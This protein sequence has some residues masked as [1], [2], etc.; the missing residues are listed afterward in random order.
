MLLL[1]ADEA[2]CSCATGVAYA[3]GQLRTTQADGAPVAVQPRS[4]PRT[5]HTTPA[6]PEAGSHSLLSTP[7]KHTQ[8][9]PSSSTF[10]AST[11]R[12]RAA[13]SGAPLCGRHNAAMSHSTRWQRGS[14]LSLAPTAS[15]PSVPIPP[16]T[17][18]GRET[19]KD[20]RDA[21]LLGHLVEDDRDDARDACARMHP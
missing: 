21:K 8:L 15:S 6:I 17:R 3:R 5:T 10:L 7:A 16:R 1:G 19:D 14:R 20:A 18:F 2:F 11:H 13:P 9:V 12:H 4:A